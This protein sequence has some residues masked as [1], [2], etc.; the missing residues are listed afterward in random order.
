MRRRRLDPK[1]RVAAPPALLAGL[2][3]SAGNF[4][5]IMATQASAFEFSATLASS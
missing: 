1:W 2:L 5:G 3:W 4:F